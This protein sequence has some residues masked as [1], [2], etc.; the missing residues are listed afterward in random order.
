MTGQELIDELINSGM[1]LTLPIHFAYNYGDHWNTEVAHEIK[2]ISGEN[3]IYSSYHNS[4]KT[5]DESDESD[6]GD[7]FKEVLILRA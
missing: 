5:V 4:H 6:D 3:V 7:P 2:S 1:D